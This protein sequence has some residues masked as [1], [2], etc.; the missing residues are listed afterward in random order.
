[1][2]QDWSTLADE[3]IDFSAMPPPIGDCAFDDAEDSGDDAEA[4]VKPIVIPV[5]PPKENPWKKSEIVNPDL[6][7]AVS[8]SMRRQHHG[9]D[10]RSKEDELQSS[11]R[12]RSEGPASSMKYVR[13]EQQG[14]RRAVGDYD[15]NSYVR[16]PREPLIRDNEYRQSTR[17]IESR[18]F[19]PSTA[20]VEEQPPSR[21]V[22]GSQERSLGSFGADRSPRPHSAPHSFHPN[23]PPAISYNPT[24]QV[25]GPPI[26]ILGAH[27][28]QSV[29]SHRGVVSHPTMQRSV[30]T[31]QSN[32]PLPMPIQHGAALLPTPIQ[33]LPAHE[34]QPR[35]SEQQAIAQDARRMD[36][37]DTQSQIKRTPR[38]SDFAERAK[39]ERKDKCEVPQ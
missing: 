14:R 30:P 27:A 21:Q 32:A 29:L 2:S 33:F 5:A 3:A 25:H 10:D 22:Q 7:N 36:H 8:D 35:S 23:L 28:S 37:R 4:S 26:S 38:S 17:A 34:P 13:K 9:R 19:R 18:V 16:E 20:V 11:Q 6:A 15:R 12:L 1:M 39:G 31:H 24:G